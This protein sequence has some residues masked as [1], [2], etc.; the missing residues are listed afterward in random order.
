MT[1]LSPHCTIECSTGRSV[2]RAIEDEP[3]QQLRFGGCEHCNLK[4]NGKLTL[5]ACRMFLGATACNVC[6]HAAAHATPHWLSMCVARPELVRDRCEVPQ[7]AKHQHCMRRHLHPA[8]KCSGCCSLATRCKQ[9]LAPS[10]SPKI[11]EI[12]M[13]P[14]HQRGEH[15]RCANP[16]TD[17]EKPHGLGSISSSVRAGRLVP[18]DLVSNINHCATVSST[19]SSTTTALR[20][21]CSAKYRQHVHQM[22]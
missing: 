1:G 14:C 6:S 11:P 4:R 5:H 18:D 17:S 15:H 8:R 7:C 13:Q 9:S 19:S 21:L 20:T 3:I 12:L 2:G 16:T 10:A 22:Q